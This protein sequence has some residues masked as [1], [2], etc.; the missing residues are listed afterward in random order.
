MAKKKR[1]E[2]MRKLFTQ[3]GVDFGKL[4]INSVTNSG[5]VV[6]GAVQKSEL[7]LTESLNTLSNAKFLNFAI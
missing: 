4:C 1:E 3:H 2:F 6:N 7:L 5:D